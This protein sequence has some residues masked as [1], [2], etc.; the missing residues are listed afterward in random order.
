MVVSI[1]AIPL[2]EDFFCLRRRVPLHV[3]WQD[4]PLQVGGYLVGKRLASKRVRSTGSEPSSSLLLMDM[5]EARENN[6]SN[7]RVE[8]TVTLKTFVTIF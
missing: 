2:G 5:H 6:C 1:V 7:N 4:E 3:S 8:I